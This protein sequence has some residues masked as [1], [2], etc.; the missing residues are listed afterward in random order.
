MSGTAP[1]EAGPDDAVAAFVRARPRLFGIAYRM[2]GSA[3][4]AEDLLQDVWM[5]WQTIDRSAVV[6]P[7]AYLAT[8]TTRLAINLAKSARARRETYVGS[9]LPEPVD[10]S[11]D[12]ALGA[13]RGQALELAILLLL[14]KLSPRERAAYVLR[15]AFN[16][17]YAELAQM[18]R[19]TEVNARQLVTRAR[20][21]IAAGRRTPV[22]AV[23]QRRLL[24]AFVSASA[25]GDV[26]ALEGLFTAD[27]ASYADGGG[28]LR[29]ARKP[30]V[31]RARVAR[32]I[33]A[34]A[35]HYW[36]GVSA[37]TI[38]ANGQPCL[39]LSRGGETTAL[40]ALTTSSEGI[41]EL[42]WIMRPSKLQAL[43]RRAAR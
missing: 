27:V 21:H 13:E 41:A 33:A 1:D 35:S 29:A 4:E 16:Y 26:A 15:E 28:M 42:L 34:L 19:I 30:V 31:G 18:L 2:L 37:D 43:A 7:S 12:P 10:T 9:W 14:E 32:F 40:L 8:T 22:S 36:T 11:A 20:Q 39:R 6:N 25:R 38:E 24:D 3:A 17:E 23:E 5:R